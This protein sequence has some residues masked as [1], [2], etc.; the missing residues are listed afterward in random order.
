MSNQTHRRLITA[1][2]LL[3]IDT[4]Q[5]DALI[6]YFALDEMTLI[7]YLARLSSINPSKLSRFKSCFH[8]SLMT[9]LCLA[10]T[11]GSSIDNSLFDCPNRV[12]IHLH[13]SLSDER[14]WDGIPPFPS[15]PPYYAG[16]DSWLK[17]AWPTFG[18]TRELKDICRVKGAS[19]ATIPMSICQ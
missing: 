14:S 18:A 16:I 13:V 3:D 11:L 12:C 5:S 10:T 8:A 17:L 19:V 7:E 4:T 1:I 9:S 15:S 6:R 2:Q